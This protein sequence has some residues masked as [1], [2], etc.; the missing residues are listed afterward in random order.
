MTITEDFLLA[1][2]RA[3]DDVIEQCLS[4]PKTQWHSMLVDDVLP[5][6]ERIWVRMDNGMLAVVHRILPVPTGEEPL[7]HWHRR[8][9]G[10][11]LKDGAYW[12]GRAFGTPGGPPPPVIEQRLCLPGTLRAMVDP[13]EWH[14]IRPE[15]HS[16]LS[17]NVFGPA[18][19]GVPERPTPKGIGTLPN[20]RLARLIADTRTIYG[21]TG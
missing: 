5:N 17:V 11:L 15:R 21:M 3:A 20:N 13:N 18:Y 14:W 9:M 16:V 4:D 1:Q 2:L 19:H 8:P 7:L 6:L 12:E 10:F